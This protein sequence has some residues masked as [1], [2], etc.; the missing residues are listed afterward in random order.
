MTGVANYPATA[1]LPVVILISSDEQQG[2]E[3]R[4]SSKTP[5]FMVVI[6]QIASCWLAV[7]KE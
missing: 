3:R 5:E 7:Y 1:L 6:V 4:V 2:I